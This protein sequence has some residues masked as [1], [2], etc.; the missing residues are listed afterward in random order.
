V[1]IL[2]E[3]NIEKFMTGEIPLDSYG[4]SAKRVAEAA[5]IVKPSDSPRIIRAMIAM[6]AGVAP[7]LVARYLDWK[8]FEGFCAGLMAARGFSVALDLRLKRPRA[9][10][11]ILAR[12]SSIALLV[13][14]K[15]WARE[16]GAAG[17][18]KVVEKQIARAALV[19]KAIKNV[20]PMAVVVLSLV[21]ERPRYVG[22]GAVVPIRAL[23][24][25]LDNLFAY[26]GELTLF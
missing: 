25:F 7:D 20:E 23:G 3:R 26:S 11:D 14:C 16:R 6:E 18:S 13:D 12:S 10:V 4:D 15:H 9:Q 2:T 1:A 24:D 17:L 22:G 21:E 5:G 8:D 19:R